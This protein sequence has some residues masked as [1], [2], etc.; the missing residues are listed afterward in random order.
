VSSGQDSA[1]RL[2]DGMVR[3]HAVVGRCSADRCALAF[4]VGGG[5]RPLRLR[6]TLATD[7][8]TSAWWNDRSPFP[9]PHGGGCL[10]RA[11]A[12]LAQG[13][14]RAAVLLPI[15]SPQARLQVT[16]HVAADEIPVDGLLVLEITD[17]ATHLPEW[18]AAHFAP[19]G[20]IGVRIDHIEIDESPDPDPLALP[21]LAWP[22]QDIPAG[23]PRGVHWSQLGDAID[24]ASAWFSSASVV[25]QRDG[26]APIVPKTRTARRIAR[27]G[28]RLMV[29]ISAWT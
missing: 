22:Q 5:G 3:G 23:V 11:L 2:A 19:Y 28:A 15:V 27:L 4:K 9:E 14:P 17:L 13:T 25:R 12:V 26:R 21:E 10:P 1:L 24:I 29:R 8:D 20:V 18:P 6:L 16:L 7:P